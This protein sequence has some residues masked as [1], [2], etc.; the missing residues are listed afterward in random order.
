MLDVGVI[1]PAFNAGRYIDQALASIAGQT[2]R[3][4]KVVV[5]DDGSLDDTVE[6]A[7]RWHDLLPIE[8]LRLRRNLGPGPARHQAIL[9]TDTAML[10]MLD[11]DDLWL[12]DHLETMAAACERNGGLVS[13]WEFSWVPGRGIDLDAARRRWSPLPE[14]P[15]DQLVALLRRNF[16]NF[17]FFPRALYDQVGGFRDFLGV[18]DWDLWIRMVRASARITRVSHPTALHRVRPGSLSMDARRMVE[19]GIAVLTAAIAEAASPRERAAAERGLRAL[20]ARERYHDVL[21]LAGDGHPWKA[22]LTAAR[23]PTGGGARLTLGLVAMAVAPRTSLR[24]E[25]AT[26]PWRVFGEG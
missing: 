2:R 25:R 18:E 12:P 13:A 20:R 3:P 7:R 6:R 9:A 15:E 23:S 19:V 21:D 24:I 14:Q 5:A 17:G 16:V 26:R 8:V 22:R 11:A 1:I 4:A 10:A